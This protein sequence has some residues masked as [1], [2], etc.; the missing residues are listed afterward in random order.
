MLHLKMT[1][2]NKYKYKFKFATTILAI[3]LAL[4]FA[5]IPGTALA[6]EA[7]T[8]AKSSPKIGPDTILV[9]IE[10][11]GGSRSGWIVRQKGYQ[12]GG[13]VWYITDQQIKMS[14]S[15]LSMI[16]NRKTKK[17]TLYSLK[18][19]RYRTYPL[20]ECAKRVGIYRAKQH[21][22]F[23]AV[24]AVGKTEYLGQ[25]AIKLVRIGQRVTDEKTR[26]D[27]EF[28]DDV[29][30]SSKIQFE[31]EINKVLESVL[32]SVYSHGL[33]FRMVRSGYIK[34]RERRSTQTLTLTEVYFVKARP[35]PD[36]EF[37]LPKGLRP[38]R[39]EMDL[40]SSDTEAE[41]L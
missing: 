33:P 10:N 25:P 11:P 5:M 37:A 7:E 17:I 18:S 2:I 19:N 38:S 34:G 3:V 29:V 28:R 27:V 36:S 22:V 6:V 12:W 26:R 21:Y 13:C 9:P 30:A 14:G 41:H 8:S 40:L 15:F 32:Y 24:K 39:S 23:G 20:A 31:P 35:I 1:S 16:I 4:F